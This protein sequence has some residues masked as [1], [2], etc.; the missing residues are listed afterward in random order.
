[1]DYCSRFPDLYLLTS[2]IEKIFYLKSVEPFFSSI[3]CDLKTI[4]LLKTGTWTIPNGHLLHSTSCGPFVH[5]DHGPSPCGTDR[6]FL[7]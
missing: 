5:K 4:T 6:T 1:M 2:D 3:R 7:N